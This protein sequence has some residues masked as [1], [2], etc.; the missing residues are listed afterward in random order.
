MITRWA[1]G[2][3]RLWVLSALI[4]AVVV[5]VVALEDPRIPSLLNPCRLLLDL[6]EEGA[7]KSQAEE[8]VA[9][10]EAVWRQERVYLLVW[11]LVPP[12]CAGLIVLVLVW[13]MRG[14]RA[15]TRL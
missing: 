10:C 9:Q 11:I 5:G 4:W 12:A 13:A 6:K 2:F 15:N 1:R 14:L 7:W 3:L 8:H